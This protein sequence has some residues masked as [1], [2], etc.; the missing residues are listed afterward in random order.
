MLTDRVFLRLFGTIGAGG[1][2]S[3]ANQVNS[4]LVPDLLRCNAALARS[5]VTRTRVS[6]HWVQ[7]LKEDFTDHE[8]RRQK[9]DVLAKKYFPL[10]E[11]TLADYNKVTQRLEADVMRQVKLD[12]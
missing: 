6:H 10:E 5:W 12:K 8:A 3:A 9:I 2:E 1:Q 11:I 7:Q 4:V